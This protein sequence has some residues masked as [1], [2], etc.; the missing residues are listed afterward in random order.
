MI[1]SIAPEITISG[2]LL[3]M[4]LIIDFF[5]RESLGPYGIY[6]HPPVVIGYHIR[7][8]GRLIVHGGFGAATRRDP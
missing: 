4:L 1:K 7:V 5:H 8:N 3:T 6:P 2:A